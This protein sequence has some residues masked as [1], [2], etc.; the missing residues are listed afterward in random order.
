MALTFLLCCEQWLS[1]PYRK[2]I[3]ATEWQRRRKAILRKRYREE[4]EKER[5]GAMGLLYDVRF[6]YAG[7]DP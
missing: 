4:K 2:I 1:N 6:S 7:T 5:A 3:P